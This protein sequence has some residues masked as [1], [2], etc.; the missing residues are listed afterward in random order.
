LI[1]T[2]L[3]FDILYATPHTL[4]LDLLSGEQMMPRNVSYRIN[5][6]RVTSQIID[7]EAII[8]NLESGNYYNLNS[9]GTDIWDCIEKGVLVCQIADAVGQRYDGNQRDIENSVSQLINELEKEELIVIDGSEEAARRPNVTMP[10]SD[11]KQAGQK[12]EA[13]VLQKYTDMQDLLLLDPIHE[14][15]ELGW[16]RAKDGTVA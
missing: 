9:T 12:F 4:F 13:P 10:A 16:P 1:A 5:T 2:T 3:V 15:D 11:S 7:G 14:V 6:P 8:I